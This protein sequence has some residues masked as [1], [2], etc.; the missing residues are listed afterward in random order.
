MSAFM[1]VAVGVLADVRQ[2]PRGVDWLPTDRPHRGAHAP[3]VR[4]RIDIIETNVD[5]V[6][7]LR[8]HGADAVHGDAVATFDRRIV[9]PSTLR[10]QQAVRFGRHFI[11]LKAPPCFAGSLAFKSSSQFTTTTIVGADSVPAAAREGH[12]GMVH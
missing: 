5:T 11:W 1:P 8:V 7:E 2:A 10:F 6:R 4:H 9:R 12:G 3:G